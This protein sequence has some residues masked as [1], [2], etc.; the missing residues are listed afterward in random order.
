MNLRVPG[1]EIWT[2]TKPLKGAAFFSLL[3]AGLLF[4][5]ILPDLP[6]F[7]FFFGSPIPFRRFDSDLSYTV[8]LIGIV[9]LSLFLL[10]F[11]R[12]LF[13]RA[14]ELTG[15]GANSTRYGFAFIPLAL[16]G[17]FANHLRYLPGGSG[18]TLQLTRFSFA[19]S[20]E[21]PSNILISIN[22]IWTVQIILAILGIGWA[23]YV[24]YKIHAMERQT[25]ESPGNSHIFSYHV[26]LLG[27]YG[28]IY[29]LLFSSLGNLA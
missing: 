13:N 27:M 22:L 6:Q 15:I 23:F 5:E 29:L 19:P 16:C 12:L 14:G 4:V 1:Q 25:T 24:L 18:L 2:Q 8:L 26:I 7:G 3:L 17:H 20:M 10:E 9:F 28:A 11:P 21:N